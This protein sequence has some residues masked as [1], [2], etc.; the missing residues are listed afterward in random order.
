MVIYVIFLKKQVAEA[1]SIVVFARQNPKQGHS[2]GPHSTAART[3]NTAPSGPSR[4]D[5]RAGL[6]PIR[7]GYRMCDPLGPP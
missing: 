3:E 1:R 5:L 7:Q 6:D 2:T 4:V